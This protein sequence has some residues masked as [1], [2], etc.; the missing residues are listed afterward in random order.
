MYGYIS[1][2]DMTVYTMEMETE[3]R[4]MGEKRKVKFKK[5]AVK[6]KNHNYDKIGRAHV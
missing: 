4:E 5:Y 2:S 3:E 1:E 6:F